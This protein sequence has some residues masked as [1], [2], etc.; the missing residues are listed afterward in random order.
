METLLHCRR[1]RSGLVQISLSLS[2]V[3][4]H[5]EGNGGSF[6]DSMSS[7]DTFCCICLTD[8]CG[9]HDKNG[10]NIKGNIK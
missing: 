8:N 9:P 3:S 5:C 6:S 4:Y 1:E 2:A 7:E 10:L